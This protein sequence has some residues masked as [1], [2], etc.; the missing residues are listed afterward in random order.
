MVNDYFSLPKELWEQLNSEYN[1]EVLS[2]QDRTDPFHI[3]VYHLIGRFKL[4]NIDVYSYLAQTTEDY[5]WLKLSV[6]C[7]ETDQVPDSVYSPIEK[8][9]LT[10]QYFQEGLLGRGEAHFNSDGRRPLAYFK[11]LLMSQQFERAIYYL[12]RT[13]YFL[14]AVHFAI[15]LDYYGLLHKTA[16]NQDLCKSFAKDLAVHFLL[17]LFLFCLYACPFDSNNFGPKHK[18]PWH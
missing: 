8:H 12:V 4:H 7:E 14:V 6:I 11:V 2:R 5:M 15:A 13:E 1:N 18:Y 17:M 3:I 9:G 10:L 16:V